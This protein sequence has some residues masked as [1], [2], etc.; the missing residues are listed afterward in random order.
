MSGIKGLNGLMKKLDRLGGN[1]QKSLK[2][3]IQQATKMAQGEAK[4]LAPVGDSGMLRN[5]IKE[6]V[7]VKNGK[8]TG[9]ISSNLYYAA[10]V[11]FGTGKRGK[12]SPSPP[13]SD[14]NVKYRQDWA[15]MDAQP[16]LYPALKNNKDKAVGIV[17][18]QLKKD[19]QKMGG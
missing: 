6:K 11:E 13:K 1:S 16:F 8:I 10:Y 19:I 2:V 4:G 3:G 5:S 15:G 12:A 17:K 14:K 9:I 7:V 18:E